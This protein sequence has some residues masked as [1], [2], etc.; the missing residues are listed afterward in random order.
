MIF[1]QNEL[2]RYNDPSFVGISVMSFSTGWGSDGVWF[3]NEELGE[4]KG[5]HEVG[6]YYYYFIII[7][8][9]IFY[10]LSQVLNDE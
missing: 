1:G 8:I 6:F 10:Y 5:F 2:Y 4:W 3:F 7:I 9:F